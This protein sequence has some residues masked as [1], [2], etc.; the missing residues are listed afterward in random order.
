MT[1]KQK[2]V[3]KSK[4]LLEVN[5]IRDLFGLRKL[6]ELPKGYPMDQNSCP[7]A[8]SLKSKRF[9]GISVSAETIDVYVNVDTED[10]GSRISFEPKHLHKFINL[11]DEGRFPELEKESY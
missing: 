11:F 9:K 4:M 5:Q 3:L 10:G 1:N 2:E 6:K 8:N 7:I